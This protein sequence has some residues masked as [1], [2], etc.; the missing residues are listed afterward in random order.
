[1]ST[2]FTN[3]VYVE[4]HL[5]LSP[6]D[7]IHAVSPHSCQAVIYTGCSRAQFMTVN[8]SPFHGNS[9]FQ[10]RLLSLCKAKL[11]WKTSAILSL[12]IFLKASANTTNQNGR[13]HARDNLSV[14]IVL[15]ERKKKINKN[16]TASLAVIAQL[17]MRNWLINTAC[18]RD[19]INCDG[20]PLNSGQVILSLFNIALTCSL[21]QHPRDCWVFT[22]I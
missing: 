16:P 7:Q 21:P 14:E 15:V 6:Q 13:W 22:A 17:D 9:Y 18:W 5:H 2:F 19:H 20:V 8:I 4:A 10:L 3:R 1:M 11:N 12:N